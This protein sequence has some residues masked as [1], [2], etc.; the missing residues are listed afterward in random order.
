MQ[1]DDNDPNAKLT[2]KHVEAIQKACGSSGL[3]NTRFVIKSLFP[4][5]SYICH[6]FL[7]FECFRGLHMHDSNRYTSLLVS[8]APYTRTIIASLRL[9]FHLNF[10]VM[11]MQI[12]VVFLLLALLLSFLAHK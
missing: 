6:S 7:K 1:I 9:E 12:M 8:C 2:H 3:L 5:D 4:E 10:L 11:F